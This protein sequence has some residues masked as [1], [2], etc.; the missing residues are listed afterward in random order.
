MRKD[1]KHKLT[2]QVQ[3]GSTPEQRAPIIPEFTDVE[4]AH[5]RNFRIESFLVLGLRTDFDSG[6]GSQADR[7]LVSAGPGL[8][9]PLLAIR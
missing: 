4:I 9:L 8:P 1:P 5:P 6:Q 2:R 3:W 7:F